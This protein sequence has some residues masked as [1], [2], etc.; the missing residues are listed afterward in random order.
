MSSAH[1]AAAPAETDPDERGRASGRRAPSD[2]TELYLDLLKRA[3]LNL[4]Y[5]DRSFPQELEE[6]A[7][8]G[9]D[10]LLE[11]AAAGVLYAAGR[12]ELFRGLSHH[13]QN[14]MPRSLRKLSA[15][16]RDKRL[17]GRDFPEQAHTMI[18]MRRLDNLQALLEQVLEA[19][20]PGD[21]IETGVWRGGSTI[22]M[23]GVLKAHG[24]TDRAVWVADS[25]EG[26]PKPGQP[27]ME[28]S[29]NSDEQAQVWRTMIRRHP[30]AVV[31]MAARLRVGTSYEEVRSTFERYGLLDGQVRFL[32]G[33]FNE[34]LPTAPISR[35]ALM[36]LDGDL[37]D[38]TYDAL[39]WLYPKL[40]SGGYVIVDDYGAFSE[41]RRAVHDYFDVTGESPDLEPVD[42]HAL[43][44]RKTAS[45]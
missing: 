10:G 9:R 19:G 44:W 25:F 40:S 32:R 21:V 14:L 27:G 30:L 4:I 29:F 17:T 41:C 23:R 34:T 7:A 43:Y 33:W 39:R 8:G 3:L 28:R 6:D 5:E 2:A 18:G 35:L 11:R 36:R 24:V 42:D 20:V 38:S 1:S 15:Y 31:V 45:N 16:D 22:F 37:Y 13:A 26:M 12:R